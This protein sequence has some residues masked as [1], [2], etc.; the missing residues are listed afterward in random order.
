[1]ILEPQKMNRKQKPKTR[2]QIP[3][4]QVTGHGTCSGHPQHGISWVVLLLRLTCKYIQR[5]LSFLW[6][7]SSH[8]LL[9]LGFG[10]LLGPPEGSSLLFQFKTHFLLFCFK[11][12]LKKKKK[13]ITRVKENSN[14]QQIL[15]ILG[16]I[17]VH[18]SH[19]GDT[20]HLGGVTLY[21]TWLS[22]SR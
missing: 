14:K 9:L 5:T 21:T 17:L 6:K 13:N 12:I 7:K 11:S 2:C 20:A 19:S 22:P 15:Y 4:P 3:S 16:Y 1:M 18:M 8:A 10:M